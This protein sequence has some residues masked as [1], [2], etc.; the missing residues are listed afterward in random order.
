MDGEAGIKFF[1]EPSFAAD[2]ADGVGMGTG[3]GKTGHRGFRG[4]DGKGELMQ[5]RQFPDPEAFDLDRPNLI[6]HVTFGAGI[7][8]CVGLAL[9]R[10]EMAVVAREVSRHLD[11]G[12]AIP[13][14]DIAYIPSTSNHSMQ[15]LP[16]TYAKR[17]AS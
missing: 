6:G 5:Q 1:A 12:L 15:R 10:M 11:I 14:G 4:P 17:G 8:R 9:A 16:L 2:G 7:H 3:A 13:V